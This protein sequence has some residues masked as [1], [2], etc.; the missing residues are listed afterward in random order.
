[1]L[2]RDKILAAERCYEF[3]KE[4]FPTLETLEAAQAILQVIELIAAK[5][6]EDVQSYTETRPPV[7]EDEE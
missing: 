1:L 7:E 4:E 5:V 3:L 6:V 2:E